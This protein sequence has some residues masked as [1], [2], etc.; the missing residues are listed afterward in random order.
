MP[1][2]GV[3]W[4]TSAESN[5]TAY[6]LRLEQMYVGPIELIS[7]DAGKESHLVRRIKGF[8]ERLTKL[9][10]SLIASS[11]ISLNAA[12]LVMQKS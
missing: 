5:A 10:I 9:S 1:G 4:I 3:T 11:D 7:R 6:M 8:W 2:L 12:W